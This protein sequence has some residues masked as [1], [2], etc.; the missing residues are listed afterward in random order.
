[1]SELGGYV[2]RFLNVD[3]SSGEL[4]DEVP[5]EALLRDFVGGYGLGA[6]VLYERMDPGADP[7]GP[8]N[9]LGF[10]TGPLTGTNA[11]MASRYCAVAKSPLTGGWGDASSGGEFG[12]AMKFAGYDAIFVEGI[13]EQPVYILID[14]GQTEIRPADDLWGLDAVETEEALMARHGEDARVACIGPAGE[15]LALISAIMNDRGRAAGRSG[16]GAVMGS[17]RLKA[18]VVRGDHAPNMAHKDQVNAL[19]KKYLPLF[20][21][22]DSAVLLRKY[23]TAGFTKALASVGRTPIK[24]WAGTYADEDFIDFDQV[25]GPAVAEYE[26]KKYACWHCVQACGGVMRWDENGKEHED[27]KPEYETLALAGTNIGVG[28]TVGVMRLNELCNRGGLDTISAGSCIGFAMECYEKGLLTAEELDGL[29]LEWGNI[30]AAFEL[31]GRIIERRG[32]GDVLADGVMRAAQKLGRGSE[33]FAIHSGGQELPAHDPRHEQ[34][35]GLVYQMSPTPGRHT[36]GGVGAR[37]MP[38]ENQEVFGLD[39]GLKIEDPTAYHAQAYA[40]S[41]SWLNVLNAAGFCSFSQFTMEPL[42]VPEFI[43]AVTGWDYEMPECI[44]TGQRI[45]VMRLLFGLREGYNP[46]QVQVAPRA[47]GRPPLETG[48]RAGVTV[49]IDDVR[50]AYLKFLDWDSVTAMPSQERLAELGLGELVGA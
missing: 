29:E 38:P 23:G 13:S 1:M 49:E 48:P 16:L 6:R 15:K 25:D 8:D 36:Q 50:D 5:D 46:L 17:K 28:D 41:M 14:D 37:D 24:N 43:A 10:V 35:F 20:K 12:P 4:S 9:I 33:A 2:G 11:L 30:E 7:L 3:L 31:L 47:M 22:G 32:L 19:R 39:P 18:I 21:T 27:H 45:E 40:T 26:T 44:T 42:Y 34:D